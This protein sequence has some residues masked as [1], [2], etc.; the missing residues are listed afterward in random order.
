[1]Y[2]PVVCKNDNPCETAIC[3]P[4]SGCKYTPVADGT[5]CEDG[6]RCT[7][8]DSC[9]NGKCKGTRVNCDDNNQFTRDFCD[10]KTGDCMHIAL[11]VSQ[12]QRPQG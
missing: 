5:T 1:V 7:V 10:P 6:D 11:R 8:N 3:D 9:R 12:G 2:T 4:K